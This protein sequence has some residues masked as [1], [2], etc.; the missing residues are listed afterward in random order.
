[1]A[2]F[3]ERAVDAVYAILT[4]SDNGLNGATLPAS[5]SAL[6]ISTADLP[7][8]AVFEKWY[9][10]AEQSTAFPYLSVSVAGT[11]GEV[12]TNSRF[13]RV[14]FDLGLVVLDSSIAGNE[15]DVLTAAWR[16]GDAIKTLF[17]RR[18]GAGGQGWTLGNASGIIRA[19]ITS[20]QVGADPGLS[21]PN[22]ALLTTI[23]VTTSESY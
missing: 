10:R 19:S 20:Q 3:T 1:M 21:V 12:E 17:Q 14:T 23:E 7:N 8:I 6:G 22:V 2:T 13:Y 5:R 15:V 18:V 9:H 11:T 4:D 16:Y